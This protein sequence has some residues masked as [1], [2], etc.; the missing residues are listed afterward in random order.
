LPRL[1]ATALAVSTAPATRPV[2][3]AGIVNNKENTTTLAR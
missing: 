2:R 3:L 1:A